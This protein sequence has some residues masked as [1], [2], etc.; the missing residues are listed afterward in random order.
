MNIKTI[1]RFKICT[2]LFANAISFPSEA[3]EVNNS[4]SFE[5]KAVLG[6]HALGDKDGFLQDKLYGLDFSY[7]KN[8]SNNKDNWIKISHAKTCGISLIIRDLNYLKGHQDT[9]INAFGQAYGLAGQVEF[10]LLKIGNASVN[11]TPAIGISYLTKTYFTDFKNR[12]IGSHL[13]QT[14]KA[15]LSI[16]VPLKSNITLLAGAGFLHYSNSGF[17]IPNSGINSLNIF[18]GLR[19]DRASSESGKHKSEFMQLPKNSIEFGFGVGR[20]GVYQEHSGLFKSGIYTGYNYHI[21]NFI[22]AKAGLDAVYY[23]SVYNPQNNLGTFQYYGTS[24][25]HWRTGVSIGGDVTMWK[26]IVNAQLGK[27]IY[28]NSYYKNIK[29]YWISGITYAITPNIGIQAKTYLHSAQAD[30]MNFGPVF[31]F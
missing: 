16:Q 2:I 19:I 11:F 17:N 21:N 25:D 30:Y 20:R 14:L 15:D 5:F 13:N 28:Y 7:L 24:Y 26:F 29:W 9:S 10:Q 8:I 22:T 18:T 12:F 31:K 27:Y 6:A 4:H 1:T 23:Y 3:Q